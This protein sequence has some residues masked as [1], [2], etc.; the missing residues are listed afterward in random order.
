MI[1]SISLAYLVFSLLCFVLWGCKKFRGIDYIEYWK[2]NQQ[3]VNGS[4]SDSEINHDLG[5][6]SKDTDD[7]NNFKTATV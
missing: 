6:K 4:E 2:D 1:V 3:S 7:G 5:K